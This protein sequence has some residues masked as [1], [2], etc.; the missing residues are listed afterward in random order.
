MYCLDSHATDIEHFWPKTPYPQRMFVWF[1]QAFGRVV[2]PHAPNGDGKT[3]PQKRIWIGRTKEAT[4]MNSQDVHELTRRSRT[5]TPI[6]T[7]NRRRT[8]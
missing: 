8:S 5:K 4:L 7:T 6:S 2:R 1:I 3:T